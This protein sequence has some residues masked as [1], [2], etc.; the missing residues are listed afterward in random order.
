LSDARRWAQTTEIAIAA[1]RYSPQAEA[2]KPARAELIDRYLVD[3]LPDQR[4]ATGPD[5][6]H[7]LRW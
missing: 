4:P 5:Q 6:E 3:V 7:R 2:K 1:G